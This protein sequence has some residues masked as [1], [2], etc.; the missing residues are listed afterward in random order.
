MPQFL[1]VIQLSS[2]NGTNGFTINGVAA[3]DNSGTSVASAGDINGDGFADLIIGAPSADPNG[4]LSGASYVVF[5][6]ASGFGNGLGNLDLA[7][8]T[9]TDGFRID[10]LVAGDQSGSTVASGGDINGDGFADLIIGSPFADPNGLTS[11]RS[12]VVFG[13]STGFGSNVNLALLDGTNGFTVN[14]LLGADTSGSS[15]A[16]AGDVN[17]DGFSDFIIGAPVA[18]PNGQF[19]GASY[20]VFGKASGF[21]ANFN[22]ATLNGTNGF[23]ISGAAAGDSVGRSVA[24]AGDFN[25]DG[26]ADVI[27]GSELADH[28]GPL[29][30]PFGAAYVVYGNSTGLVA[31]LVLDTIN[32]INGFKIEGVAQGDHTGNSVASAGD[33]NGDGYSD[34]IIGADLATTANGSFSG[35]SY[36]VFG[37]ATGFATGIALSALDGSNGF[38]LNGEGTLDVSGLSVASAGDVNGDG[39][40]DLII[41]APEGPNNTHAGA[42]YVVFGKATG[43]AASM[44]LSALTGND[45]FKLS[46]AAANNV[47]GWQVASAGD[48]NADGFSDIIIGGWGANPNANAAAGS[49]YV[50]FGHRPD[51]AIAFTGSNLGQK[52]HGSDFA[53]T[54]SG[55]GGSDTIIGY[56]GDDVINGDA[57]NDNLD[58]GAGNDS[59]DGGTG[60]DVMAGG[61]GDDVLT[62]GTGNDAMNG[63]SGRDTL[64]GG[65]GA[66]AMTGGSEDDLYIIDNA[67]D[68]VVEL[69]GGGLD[70]VNT[71]LNTLSIAPF[72]NVENLTFSGVGGFV[73]TGNSSSNVIIGGAGA[74][75]LFGGLGIDTLIGGAGIDRLTGGA[76][77][78]F[79][80]GGAQRDIFDF[81]IK[82]ESGKTAS[83]RDVITDFKHNLD[84]IDVRT[85]DA[86][87]H[88]A[89]NQNFIFIGKAAFHHVSGELHYATINKA[90][91]INDKTTVSG[92]I[93]GDGKADFS[94]ELSHLVNLTKGDF[95][96]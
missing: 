55:N 57:G 60:D 49:S 32:G 93:N 77:R 37:A 29:N 33:I 4:S 1:P 88:K 25:G 84:D 82:T 48:V 75:S 66:D 58:G 92:D 36:V 90:G 41:G 63:G 67:G 54:F 31:N 28:P 70:L 59:L 22:L 78:D 15:V 62:A 83:T 80:T 20:V 46:G 12:Y 87:S 8:L 38:K 27:V 64:N 50:V 68:T 96:L 69:A 39:F 13:K 34:V 14:G 43:F 79:L 65:S 3:G 76:G 11:G 89:G 56:A 24:S 74:D 5:G 21:S 2:L 6:K 53:D 7:T 85:I 17:H 47:A 51:A 61:N 72:G 42:S 16:S 94:I 81:N 9:A 71:S 52:T 44:E 10:G 23:K 30:T 19:S 86:N 73:G 95:I 40:A 18:S 35:T 26:F 45:G 91:T